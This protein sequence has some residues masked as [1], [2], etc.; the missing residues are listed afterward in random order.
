VLALRRIH[1]AADCS[2]AAGAEPT[3]TTTGAPAMI[4][5]LLGAFLVGLGLGVWLTWLVM[6]RPAVAPAGGPTDV[7]VVAAVATAGAPAQLAAEHAAQEIEH[8]TDAELDAI[9]DDLVRRGRARK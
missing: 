3:T 1:P 4:Y 9:V 6:R 8:A 2:P 7:A 5:A